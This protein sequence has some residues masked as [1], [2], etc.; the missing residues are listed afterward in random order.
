MMLA[1]EKMALRAELV[2]D[3]TKIDTELRLGLAFG[4]STDSSPSHRGA[5]EARRLLTIRR[6]ICDE[7]ATV[8]FQPWAIPNDIEEAKVI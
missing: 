1:S 3:L 8:G 6:A 4:F 2:E 7:M 5:A